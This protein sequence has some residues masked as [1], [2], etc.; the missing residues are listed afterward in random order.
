MHVKALAY[1]TSKG[2]EKTIL[3]T[4]EAS[5]EKCLTVK[6]NGLRST[7]LA[8]HLRNEKTDNAVLPIVFS[9]HCPNGTK[10]KKCGTREH[11]SAVCPLE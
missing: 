5:S 8:V 4:F 11:T 10:G 7:R 6:S 1:K 3:A 2:A 9:V